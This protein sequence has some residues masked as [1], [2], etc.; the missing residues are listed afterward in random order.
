MLIVPQVTEAPS[1]GGTFKVVNLFTW[2]GIRASLVA[3][4]ARDHF[5][6]SSEIRTCRA[7]Y[8]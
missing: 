1:T 8:W 7:F 2:S 6:A 4:G 3:R 5:L